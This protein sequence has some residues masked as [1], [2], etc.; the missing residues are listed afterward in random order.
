MS[1]EQ[2]LA[3]VAEHIENEARDPAAV[4][5][6]YTDDV[7]QEFPTRGLRFDT[8]PAIEANY[9][10]MF[11]AIE[12]VE[13]ETLDRF[14]TQDRVVDDMIVR[15]NMVREGMDNCPIPVGNKVILRLVHVFHMR[16]GKI[17]Q[18]IVH[19]NWQIG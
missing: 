1:I 9:R 2:N 6:L 5:A 15:F 7:V 16:D 13:M 3:V 8:K 17:A 14:A 19:E 4:L 18:E 10:R 12:N 11:A